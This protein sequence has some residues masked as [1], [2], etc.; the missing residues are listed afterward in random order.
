MQ[1]MALE[2][3]CLKWVQGKD[4]GKT[5]YDA[6]KYYGLVWIAPYASIMV[7]Y[8]GDMYGSDGTHGISLN[9]WR[10]I[11]LCVNNSLGTPVPVAM[12]FCTSENQHVLTAMI[13]MLNEVC[14]NRGMDPPFDRE[15]GADHVHA[16]DNLA[17]M[18]DPLD[19]KFI[20]A[21]EW[22]PFVHSIIEGHPNFELAPTF[23]VRP[24]FM[25]DGGPA[26]AV[27]AHQFD[28]D[29]VLCKMHLQ[30][31]NKLGQTSKPYAPTC[32]QHNLHACQP[33]GCTPTHHNLHACHPC[34]CTPTHHNLHAC[35][36]CGCT[37]TH[38]NLHACQP[39]GCTPTHHNFHACHTHKLD[40]LY[41]AL[42][43][44]A[45]KLI[46]EDEIS[47]K[48]ALQLIKELLSEVAELPK[49]AEKAKNWAND[50]FRNPADVLKT[51]MAF[52]K[53]FFTSSWR[54]TSGLENWFNIFKKFKG[55]ELKRAMLYEAIMLLL[56]MVQH[57][58]SQDAML[59]EQNPAWF[60]DM[61]NPD[62]STRDAV[63][64]HK[65][66][67]GTFRL[68][69]KELVKLQDGTRCCWSNATKIPNKNMWLLREKSGETEQLHLVDVDGF[70]WED[71]PENIP[72]RCLTCP[73]HRNSK[74]PCIGILT[75]LQNL[76]PLVGPAS[77]SEWLGK[78]GLCRP[79]IFAN[80]WRVDKD[81]TKF[82]LQMNL[83]PR[84]RSQASTS[85]TRATCST[86][87]VSSLDDLSQKYSDQLRRVEKLSPSA[88]KVALDRMHASWK[89]NEHL[90]AKFE[91][92]ELIHKN[93]KN[94]SWGRN[95]SIDL[96][97]GTATQRKY[98]PNGA[99]A[100]SVAQSKKRAVVAAQKQAIP[101]G[102]SKNIPEEEKWLCQL[103]N[104][105]VKN[106]A[107]LVHQHCDGSTH[108]ENVK[109]WQ[110][111][112]S[113]AWDAWT[114]PICNFEV[115][116]SEA[117]TNASMIRQHRATH[118]VT[119][120]RPRDANSDASSKKTK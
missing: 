94:G 42:G 107:Y 37:P 55:G 100:S 74:I 51:V 8:F 30:A 67:L 3:G 35:Q 80:R 25:T 117:V 4:I 85:A 89:Q 91:L 20:C 10:A 53:F 115:I 120:K 58:L 59:I 21:P 12:V 14:T 27:I 24:S 33:C 49:S 13:R 48:T 72:P 83:A 64:D 88:Q 18:E 95:S 84:S 31:L 114:C 32:I 81:P 86:S 99:E 112:G 29:H 41:R 60:I 82:I 111:K 110:D 47:T 106:A 90:L 62:M 102:T 105:K 50:S 65:K 69:S 77:V 5:E 66:K 7:Q 11:P 36:P 75:L 109:N 108:V 19:E 71:S 16:R 73:F 54:A 9:N 79:E 34:G 17:R 93:A 26:F 38:H 44:A 6:E 116:E 1:R 103:C 97:R 22:R 78:K 57:R 70:C 2:G 40:T 45:K 15:F 56:K 52:H 63:D 118:S 46:W 119:L 39:C 101:A 68:F 87:G 28:L 98:P 23:A 104:R 76:T 61:R 43:D 96:Q 113:K 92:D